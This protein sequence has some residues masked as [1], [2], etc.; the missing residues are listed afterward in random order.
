MHLFLDVPYWQAIALTTLTARVLLFPLNVMIQKSSAKM[1]IAQPEMNKI[2]ESYSKQ[3]LSNQAVQEQYQSEMKALFQKN[4]L[5][6]LR[7][8]ILPFV[9]IPLFL[10]FFFGLRDMGTLVSKSSGLLLFPGFQTGGAMW[11]TDLAAADPYMILPCVN[12]LSF[13]LMVEIGAGTNY[14]Y[15]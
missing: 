7:G 5:N 2:Q 14:C 15:Q 9:Q 1:A 12:A 6:P 11:F 3:D 8:I 10:S 4:N 13:L